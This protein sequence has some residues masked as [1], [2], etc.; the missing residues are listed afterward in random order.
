[1]IYSYDSFLR[2]EIDRVDQFAAYP[3]WLAKYTSVR[4]TTVPGTWKGWKIWQH[5]SSGKVP[6]IT[7]RV[8][9]NH[10]NGSYSELLSF[11]SGK[12]HAGVAQSRVQKH[13]VT[14][15]YGRVDRDFAGQW[16]L[17]QAKTKKGWK[18]ASKQRVS[19]TGRYS[20]PVKLTSSTKQEH[21]IVLQATTPYA[22]IRSNAVTVR[23]VKPWIKTTFSDPTV[24]RRVVTR[25]RGT[26][27]SFYAGEW[28]YRQKLVGGRWK[29]M[30]S[31]RV[32]S[33][34]RYDF[35]MGSTTR[36]KHSYRVVL[37]ATKPNALATS[38][39]VTLRVR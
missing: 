17:R 30:S 31:M 39:T 9:L 20:F 33:T 26:V 1:M 2:T 19:S 37:R 4:P 7:G 35:A 38:R 14:R 27:S 25:L 8:D 28:V 3:L 21:R 23:T 22:R 12:V 32:S 10:F 15:V 6:G 24:K 34:G 36:G 16:I 13:E 29:T 5:T 18:T 11:A